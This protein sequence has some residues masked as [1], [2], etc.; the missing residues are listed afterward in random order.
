M[1]LA[2][3]FFMLMIPYVGVDQCHSFVVADGAAT[4]DQR[5]DDPILGVRLESVEESA[6]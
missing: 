3:L 2:E 6:D 5:F 1:G 4:L